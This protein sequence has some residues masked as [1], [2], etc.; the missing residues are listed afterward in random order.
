MLFPAAVAPQLCCSVGSAPHS[1]V[2]LLALVVE[3]GRGFLGRVGG[4]RVGGGRG[5]LGRVGGGRGRGGQGRTVQLRDGLPLTVTGAGAQV[6]SGGPPLLRR[7]V[8]VR[9]R[10]EGGDR[11]QWASRPKLRKKISFAKNRPKSTPNGSKAR[12]F[13]II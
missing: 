2:T 3:R 7:E 10:G 4:G 9:G 12:Y 5:C 13:C 1:L 6:V 8:G 11:A